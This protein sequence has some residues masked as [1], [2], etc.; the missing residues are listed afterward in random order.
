MSETALS[1]LSLS[2]S[3]L[4]LHLSLSSLTFDLTKPALS[5]LRVSSL[6]LSPPIS[7]LSISL[8]SLSRSRV[9]SALGAYRIA[10]IADAD[11][12]LGALD[13]RLLVR[14][15]TAENLAARATVVLGEE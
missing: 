11:G 9:R 10:L 7:F 6:S 3:S 8:L 1:S 13:Q 2:L 5:H 14:A 15:L 12:L 4:A